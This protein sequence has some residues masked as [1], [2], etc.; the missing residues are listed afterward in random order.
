MHT[1]EESIQKY[2]N[3]NDTHIIK[4]IRELVNNYNDDNKLYVYHKDAF[5]TDKIFKKNCLNNLTI[6]YISDFYFINIVGSGL[7][8]FIVNELYE[9]WKIHATFYNSYK[10][11]ENGEL[12]SDIQ[13]LINKSYTELISVPCKILADINQSN[14]DRVYVI[15]VI[16][17][18]DLNSVIQDLT[19][20]DLNLSS[21][22]LISGSLRDNVK[23]QISKS[24]D[25]II[26]ISDSNKKIIL[27]KRK[28]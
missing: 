18:V 27:K 14:I 10:R 11:D 19:P 3:T 24:I 20:K 1:L 2:N 23:K 28:S 17:T 16:R 25:K 4:N 15:C 12:N 21:D 9:S 26:K 5:S 13:V 7:T 8:L 6:P 22:N